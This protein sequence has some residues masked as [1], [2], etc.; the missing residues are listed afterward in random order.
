MAK[1]AVQSYYETTVFKDL[2]TDIVR[3][4]DISEYQ[5]AIIPQKVKDVV[6]AFYGTMSDNTKRMIILTKEIDGEWEV[7]NEG[8]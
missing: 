1:K 5:S 4:T 7:I 6:I 2:V 3:I 8:V